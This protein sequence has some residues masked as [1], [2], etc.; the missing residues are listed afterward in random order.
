VEASDGADALKGY[1]EK[2]DRSK[3][4]IVQIE[5]GD[6]R[7]YLQAPFRQDE[8]PDYPPTQYALIHPDA[9]NLPKR[10]L[11]SEADVDAAFQK[12]QDAL[13]WVVSDFVSKDPGS[14][15]VSN[16][17][18]LS[19]TLPCSGYQLSTASLRKS[20]AEL[21]KSWGDSPVPPKYVIV[22]RRS[23]SLAQT[24]QVLA[25]ALVARRRTGK[26]PDSVAVLDVYGPVEVPN[27]T[28]AANGEVSASTVALAAVYI[29]PALYEDNWSP[30]PRNVVPSQ[31]QVGDITV[32]GAQYLHLMMKALLSDDLEAKLPV[33][34]AGMVWAP[35]AVAF[36]TR[37]VADMGT[38]WTIKPAPIDISKGAAKTQ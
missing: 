34:P 30:I 35:E 2:L 17:D 38:I 10:A 21:D 28:G 37:P 13:K 27:G 11:N 14:E 3:I 9:P 31:V 4:R 19:M 25:D 1:F 15:I 29:L 26:L 22:D 16:K 32:N 5:L 7:N 12:E 20:I 6:D 8:S 36:R 18:L 23:L 33:T 24:F